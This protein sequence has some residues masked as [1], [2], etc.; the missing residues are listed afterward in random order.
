MR[1]VRIVHE[2]ENFAL[3]NT[4]RLRFI[5]EVGSV[6]CAVRTETYVERIGRR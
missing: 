2:I 3:H 4:S 1:F 5:T 6:H